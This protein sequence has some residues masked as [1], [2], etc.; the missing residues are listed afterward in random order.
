MPG[1]NR[2]SSAKSGA[3]RNALRA[4]AAPA[5]ASAEAS[6]R[7]S[8]LMG[9]AG[10][11]FPVS[12]KQAVVVD[13]NAGEDDVLAYLGK[14][15]KGAWLKLRKQGK[16]EMADTLWLGKSLKALAARTAEGIIEDLPVEAGQ[17]AT[18][19]RTI[20]Y[21][22]VRFFGDHVDLHTDKIRR[23]VTLAS[24]LLGDDV[25]GDDSI[26]KDSIEDRDERTM[27]VRLLDKF[28]KTFQGSAKCICTGPF[29]IDLR[30]DDLSETSATAVEF[31]VD[32]MG[33]IDVVPQAATASTAMVLARLSNGGSRRN[34]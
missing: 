3:K 22:L 33:N 13:A 21:W 8:R 17:T 26:W 9:E 28:E 31:V 14:R 7:S 24:N 20:E 19:D 10:P 27:K 16:Y 30:S 32:D 18:T 5:V 1:S 6:R 25:R 23:A 34:C 11:A 12:Q 4:T 2:R 15:D 29:G